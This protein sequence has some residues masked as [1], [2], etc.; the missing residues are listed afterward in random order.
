MTRR[1]PVPLP[2]LAASRYGAAAMALL[3][4]ATAARPETPAEE[5]WAAAR[6]GDIKA[7]EALLAKGVDVNAKT[8]YGA[9][10]LWF[11]ANKGHPKVMA[12]LLKKGANPDVKDTLW[13]ETPLSMATQAEAEAVATEM[14]TILLEAGAAGAPQLLTAAA[15]DGN[16]PVV[17]VLLEKGKV[18]AE[19]KSAALAAAPDKPP[20]VADLLRKAGARPLAGLATALPAQEL[21]TLAGSYET[22]EGFSVKV[23]VKDGLLVTRSRLGVV[24]FKPA[25]ADKFTA[26]IGEV[27]TL[28]VRRQG[29]K[30][31]GVDL[32]RGTDEWVCER[33]ESIRLPQPAAPRVEETRVAVTAPR[34][35]PS[36]R[37]PGATGLADGQHPP[38]I[39]DA[40]KGLNVRWKVPIPGVGHSCPVVC[41]NR[42][43]VTTAV[44][45]DPKAPFKTGQYGGGNG[46]K[47]FSVHS[48]RVY[49]LDKSTGKILWEREAHKGVPRVDRHE[50]STQASATPATDGEHLVVV[51]GSEGLFCYDLSG[52]LLW[53]QDLGVLDLGAF[54]DPEL[55]W[56]AGSSPAIYKGLVIV[57]CDRPKDGFLAAFDV[58]SGKPVWRTT[59][60]EPPSWG[61]PNVVEVGGRAELVANGSRFIRGYDPLTGKELWRLGP[62]SEI[63]VP[64]PF[65][66]D[67]LIFVANGYRPIQPIYAVLPGASGD[68]SPK[69]GG[70]PGAYLAWETKKGS[71]YLPTPIVY[72]S[73]FYACT[74]QGILTAYEARTGK[75]V[76]KRRLGGPGGY[77][78]SPVAADGRIYFTCE[79][80]EVR[81]VKAGPEFELLA[82][83]PVGEPCLATPAI[84][85][86]LLIMRS[87][88]TVFAFGGKDAKAPA[89]A[90]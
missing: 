56:G 71:P 29:G 35:W 22:R 41:G 87:R 82:V 79:D 89:K 2:L 19:A 73:L 65:A 72:G 23:A 6:G 55:K 62:N 86:G 18:P 4:L 27:V 78:A 31:A 63:T 77:T 43:F 53:R 1:L 40:E 61:T 74:N 90:P 12:L 54:N 44:S 13:G 52:N 8:H 36:F 88:N 50:K 15:A 39:W 33:S 57:Q 85:D 14:L 75:Q 26:V 64:T 81:V 46:S 58:R 47:D 20:A 48:W 3:L 16:A 69:E 59:R 24:V 83:N 9:S 67:G 45:G 10:A 76:Y 28:T 60:D 68:I 80:G 42:V 5:L 70:G 49:C 21:T 34:D 7:V 17:R 11:A 84:S 32:R 25:A 37:G 66:A 38:T 51:F 30:P